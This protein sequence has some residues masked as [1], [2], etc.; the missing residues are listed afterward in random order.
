MKRI[1]FKYLPNLY[2]D[3]IPVHGEATCN[4]CE[5]KVTEYIDQVYSAEDVYSICLSFIHDGSVAEKFNAEFVQYGEKVS[6]PQNHDEFQDT[7]PGSQKRQWDIYS[8]VCITVNTDYM[9]M[10]AE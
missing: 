1:E 2:S 5:K 8:V 9:S 7:C 3:E 6:D 10:Q 4:C